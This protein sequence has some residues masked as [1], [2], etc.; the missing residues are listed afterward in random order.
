MQRRRPPNAH[1]ADPALDGIWRAHHRYLLDVAYRMLGSVSEAEDIVQDAFAKLLDADL[2]EIQDVRGWL[3]VAVTRRC[4]DQ[5]RSARARREVYVGPWLPEPVIPPAEGADPA[6]RV[7]L[8]DSVRMALLIVLEQLSPAERAAFVLHDV[9]QFSFEEVAS[10]VGRSPEACRQLASR[11]RRRVRAEATPA[12]FQVDPA[13][14][15]RVAERFVA[16]A[17]NGD[18]DALMHVL[19]PNVV[20]HTDSGGFVAG[21]RRPIAGRQL[22]ATRILAFLRH[23]KVNLV[24]MPVNGEPGLLA[25]QDG[26]LVAV[27]ALEV[28]DGLITHLHGI[29]NPHKLAYVSSILDAMPEPAA[30]RPVP[31]T[32]LGA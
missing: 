13:D 16:A 17:S 21:L 20:G 3:V 22:V 23:Q 12:R 19:D 27:I 24:P 1:P 31:T 29:A 9:F 32:S 10:I 11:A 6:D 7:T 15:S 2:G 5:L 4:L 30:P 25:F 18:L 8:D 28:R 26:R 14:L